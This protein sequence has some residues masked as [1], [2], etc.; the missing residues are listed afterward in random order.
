GAAEEV[1]LTVAEPGADLVEVVHGGGHG[2][3]GEV[4]LLPE[5]I[6]A[7]AHGVQRELLPEMALEIVFPAVFAAQP[8]GLPGPSLVD[9]DEVALPAQGIRGQR[10]GGGS[11][12]LAGAAGEVEDGIGERIRRKRREHHDLEADLAA[13]LRLPVLPDLVG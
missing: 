1:D 3:A 11:V 12:R 8:V 2:V 10:S 4:V 5:L 6:A 7:A 9:E 13:G